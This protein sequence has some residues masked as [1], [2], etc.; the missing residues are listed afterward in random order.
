MLLESNNSKS[1]CCRSVLTHDPAESRLFAGRARFRH[2]RGQIAGGEQ[3]VS[4]EGEGSVRRLLRGRW[5]SATIGRRAFP[6]AESAL[7]GTR[8]WASPGKVI[9]QLEMLTPVRTEDIVES[10]P[11]V[12]CCWRLPENRDYPR[13]IERGQRHARESRIRD[14]DGVT[15]TMGWT[16]SVLAGERTLRRLWLRFSSSLAQATVLASAARRRRGVRN[17]AV[18]ATNGPALAA[19]RP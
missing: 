6:G 10:L 8:F 5:L 18:G 14:T 7:L 19:A 9:V 15:F 3:G 2:L 1:W 13:R 11:Q 16:G 4:E 17:G 12:K